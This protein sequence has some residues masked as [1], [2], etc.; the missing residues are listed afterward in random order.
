MNK[1][2]VTLVYIH[3]HALFPVNY[4]AEHAARAGYRVVVIGEAEWNFRGCETYSRT[5]YDDG[6]EDFRAT[7]IHMGPNAPDYEAF[8][9]ERWFILRN[10]MR[11][12]DLRNVI[13]VDSDALVYDG[14]EA[15]A[16]IADGGFL[17]TPYINYFNSVEHLDLITSEIEK[18]FSDPDAHAAEVGTGRTGIRYYSDMLLFPQLA[19]KFPDRVRKWERDMETHGFDKNIN[20]VGDFESHSD[21][22][23]GVKDVRLQGAVPVGRTGDGTEQSFRFLH[24]QGFSKPLMQFYLLPPLDGYSGNWWPDPVKDEVVVAYEN[25]KEAR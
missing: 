9:F 5:D 18:T 25:L 11:E 1:S 15:I 10:F 20:L 4:A 16:D 3:K 17:D 7:Y 24:F 13:Y 22:R 14:I 8:C 2:D 6:C 23:S 19:R 12:H 21:T